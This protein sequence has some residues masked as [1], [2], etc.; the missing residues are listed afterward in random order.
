[1]YIYMLSHRHIWCNFE[2]SFI[3]CDSW[4]YFKIWN[5]EIL[6]TT[7]YYEIMLKIHF[8]WQYP[9]IHSPHTQNTTRSKSEMIYFNACVLII[10]HYQQSLNT[11]LVFSTL[12]NKSQAF[13]H[14]A[15]HI[16][17]KPIHPR[18][19]YY[20]ISI[21]KNSTTAIHKHLHSCQL[22]HL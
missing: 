14:I 8:F 22:M 17:Y 13:L 6:T 20:Q 2:K 15:A 7:F 12:A 9:K 11:D 18:N 21:N 5:S 1:M 4:I 3:F 10:F 16:T 19:L